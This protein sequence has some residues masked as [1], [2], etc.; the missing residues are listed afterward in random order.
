MEDETT[1]GDGAQGEPEEALLRED[2][3]H[4]GGGRR[5]DAEIVEKF[6]LFLYGFCGPSRCVAAAA[7]SEER[8]VGKECRN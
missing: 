6:S 4:R 7:R 2:A 8:R 1:H 5:R 3:D